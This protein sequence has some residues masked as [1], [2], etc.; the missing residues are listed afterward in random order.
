MPFAGPHRW[1]WR[2]DRQAFADGCHLGR[3]GL[4][5]GLRFG[6]RGGGGFST[7]IIRFEV[8][9]DLAGAGGL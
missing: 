6:G 4:G 2:A 3:D 1:F 5:P 9:G 8:R 7:A